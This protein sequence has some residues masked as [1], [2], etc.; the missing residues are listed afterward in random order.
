MMQGATLSCHIAMNFD[1]VA[2]T[3]LTRDSPV[4]SHD[5]ST[6]QAPGRVFAM[7]NCALKRMIVGAT[8][9]TGLPSLLV[10]PI[11]STINHC[12]TIVT[13]EA[14][15]YHACQEWCGMAPFRCPRVVA[16]AVLAVVVVVVSAIKPDA[17]QRQN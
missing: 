13:K 16:G 12:N 1:T 3:A 17:K 8:I 10:C 6:M 11:L 2:L 14:G 5:R 4:S 15:Q 9:L 7:R